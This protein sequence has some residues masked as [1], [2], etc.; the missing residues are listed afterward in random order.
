MATEALVEIYGKALVTSY[1]N[2]EQESHTKPAADKHICSALAAFLGGASTWRQMPS[3]HM[4]VRSYRSSDYSDSQH[5]YG[6]SG[7]TLY[8]SPN[9]LDQQ[10]ATTEAIVDALGV[11]GLRYTLN[12]V[13]ADGV[14]RELYFLRGLRAVLESRPLNPDRIVPRR[15][16]IE[17]FEQGFPGQTVV[18]GHD[19]TRI[20]VS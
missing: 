4:T 14:G 8:A 20:F 15:Y 16:N 10:W 19:S 11:D 1:M 9:W 2:I 18:V 3:R 7:Y 13:L 17:Y 12:S 6:W 5:P